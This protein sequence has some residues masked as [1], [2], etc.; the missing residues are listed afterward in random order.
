MNAA[1]SVKDSD[2]SSVRLMNDCVSRSCEMLP[3][4]ASGCVASPAGAS[5]PTQYVTSFSNEVIW[6][7]AMPS[8]GRDVSSGKN[9]SLSRKVG[10]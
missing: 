2:A 4:G 1:D 6:P 8:G 5:A 10:P 7:V 9:T 3:I